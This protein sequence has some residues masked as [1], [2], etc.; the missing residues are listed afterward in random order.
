MT[1]TRTIRPNPRNKTHIAQVGGH[2]VILP[3]DGD[4]TYI[5]FP[6]PISAYARGIA[7]RRAEQRA[8]RKG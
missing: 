2:T 6:E 5:T 1:T 7:N 8:K 4:I 3:P